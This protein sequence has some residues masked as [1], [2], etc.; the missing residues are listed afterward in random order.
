M[1]KNFELL[2][3]VEQE[4]EAEM[5]KSGGQSTVEY[6]GDGAWSARPFPELG[7]AQAS[8]D[9]LVRLT[10]N[11]FLM[12]GASKAVVFS[13][14]ERG[15]GA[16]W[17][18]SNVAQLLASQGSGSVC[19][20]DANLR[21]PAL[22]DLFGIPNHHGLA[23]AVMDSAPLTTFLKQMSPPNLWLL[24]CGSTEKR[25]EARLSSENLR[26][27]IKQLCNEFDFVVI[28]TPALNL[29]SDAVALATVTDGL[30]VV[31]KANS[32]RRETAQRVLRDLKTS[33]VKLLGAVL[34]QRQFPIPEKLYH[35]L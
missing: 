35:K 32:S 7:L 9:Q 28:D 6:A 3:K 2:Q 20:V 13:G 4:R 26:V 11:L 8:R 30:A 22:H 17:V 23:D 15:T 31:L 29:Y 21:S 14:V 18:A 10:Q 16:T 12:P 27:R 33:N 24:T 25:E 1:S 34:N 19:L 5:R